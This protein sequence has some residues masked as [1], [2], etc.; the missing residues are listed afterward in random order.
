M[1]NSGKM[2]PNLRTAQ[3]HE[4]QC[5]FPGLEF[6]GPQKVAGCTSPRVVAVQPRN[7]GCP[8]PIDPLWILFCELSRFSDKPKDHIVHDISICNYTYHIYIY[9]CETPHD[10][11]WYFIL[12]T[13]KIPQTDADELDKLDGFP[14]ELIFLGEKWTVELWFWSR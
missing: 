12:A 11:P 7:D 3:T 14:T 13:P 8:L 1:L 5:D 4:L 2:I 10:I 6:L 9:I